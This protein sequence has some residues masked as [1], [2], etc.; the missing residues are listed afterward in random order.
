MFVATVLQK[1]APTA[2]ETLYTMLIPV[3]DDETME[4]IAGRAE[5]AAEQARKGYPTYTYRT[6]VGEL[7]HEIEP[8]KPL[9]VKVKPLKAIKGK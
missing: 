4:A 1:T 2:R 9:V 3:R 6:L 7:T 8:P 5:M